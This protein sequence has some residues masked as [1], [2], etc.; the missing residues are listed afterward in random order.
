MRQEVEVSIA[1]S[2]G[3]KSDA[4]SVACQVE[5]Q[6]TLCEKYLFVDDRM[7]I[8]AHPTSTNQRIRRVHC[9]PHI[10]RQIHVIVLRPAVIKWQTP[11]SMLIWRL[12][13]SN[14]V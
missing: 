8:C 5:A 6:T 14:S 4:D 7:F 12:Y 11:I 1:H 13:A 3:A 10:A 2:V 9:S